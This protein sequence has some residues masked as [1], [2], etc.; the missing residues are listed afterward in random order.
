MTFFIGLQPLDEEWEAIFHEQ[1]F[2]TEFREEYGF[3]GVFINSTTFLCHQ[4][5]QYGDVM[6]SITRPIGA[7]RRELFGGETP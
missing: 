6:F 7:Y 1:G 5:D 2:V 4:Y 3:S